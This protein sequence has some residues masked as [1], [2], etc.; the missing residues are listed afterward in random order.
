MQVST[1]NV[2][3]G[4]VPQVGI[5]GDFDCIEAAFVRG[6]GIVDCKKV[7]LFMLIVE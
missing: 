6:G 4:Q 3:G 5:K 1:F 7:S 2:T